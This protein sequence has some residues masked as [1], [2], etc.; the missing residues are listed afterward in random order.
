MKKLFV[1]D[2]DDTLI[3]NVQDY[4]NPILNACGLINQTLGSRA[5]HVSKLIAIEQEIDKRRIKEINP[6]TNKPYLY[7]MERFP[8][9]L[10]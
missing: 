9:S 10:V 7:S 8:S 4:A 6:D 2:L 1:F 3:D 5:P